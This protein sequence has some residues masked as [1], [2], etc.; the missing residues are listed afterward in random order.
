MPHLRR[1]TPADAAAY[2]TV[3]LRGL[4]ECPS[5]FGSSYSTEAKRSLDTFTQRLEPTADTWTFGA[6]DTDQLVG[7]VTLCRFPNAKERHKAGIY[8]MFVSRSHRQIGIGR[9][10]VQRALDQARR[11]RGIKQ[12]QLGVNEA[13]Q[14]AR[15]L[16]ESFNFS[17]F[18]REENAL[19]VGGK[20]H[21]ELH[22]AR[23]L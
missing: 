16:Y 10:L 19:K 21:H 4:R 11:L 12:L 18:G 22:M 15:K 7:V 8:G 9:L 13:N 14:P 5:A 3:R 23:A 2:R 17:V 6:F 20:F 1:L